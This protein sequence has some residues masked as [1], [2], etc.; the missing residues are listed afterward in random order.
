L[1]PSWDVNGDILV[2]IFVAV[3]QIRNLKKLLLRS[4][5]GNVVGQPER[6]V[7]HMSGPKLPFESGGASSG[8]G[9]LRRACCSVATDDIVCAHVDRA[10][11]V[12]CASARGRS[13][14]SVGSDK[15]AEVSQRKKG[16]F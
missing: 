4:W 9:S 16:N 2:I 3:G 5:E 15:R 6:A 8:P 7:T 12:A 10:S 14:G 13:Q 1:K 11:F